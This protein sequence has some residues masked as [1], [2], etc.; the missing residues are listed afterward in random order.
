MNLQIVS[1]YASLNGA[2]YL[3]L[4]LGVIATR[5]HLKVPYGDNNQRMLIKKRAVSSYTHFLQGFPCP[6]NF[7]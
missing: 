5:R 7:L 3:A 4:S 1:L 2:L 6:S